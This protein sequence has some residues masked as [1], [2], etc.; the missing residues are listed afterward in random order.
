MRPKD[1]I[2]RWV[3]DTLT[4]EFQLCPEAVHAGAHLVDDLDLDSIDAVDLAVNVERDFG[5]SL[6]EGDLKSLHTVQDVVDLLHD[7]L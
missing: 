1:E 6:S 2:Q 5:L 3:L 4:S 7:R